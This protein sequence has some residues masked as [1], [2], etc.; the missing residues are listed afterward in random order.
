MVGWA[1]TLIDL[2]LIFSDLFLY[3]LENMFR[4]EIQLSFNAIKMILLQ[5]LI[6]FAGA[7]ASLDALQNPAFSDI[8]NVVI[9]SDNDAEFETNVISD[10][11]FHNYFAIY[12]SE[13]HASYGFFYRTQ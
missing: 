6:T 3:S 12:C 8:V 1:A 4:V 11:K 9:I 2:F 13:K 10:C 7:M 5:E